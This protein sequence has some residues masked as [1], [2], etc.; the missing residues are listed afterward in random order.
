M[1]ATGH[2]S[3]TEPF[4]GLFTQ[5]MVTHETYKNVAGEW[6]APTEIDLKGEENNREAVLKGTNKPVKIGSIEKKCRSR[7]RT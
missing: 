1:K 3:V 7:K 4:K 2:L 6:V 5:G